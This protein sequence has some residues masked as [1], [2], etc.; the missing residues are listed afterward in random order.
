MIFIVFIHFHEGVV[1]IK[2]LNKAEGLIC[3]LEF[4][5]YT[6]SS[7]KRIKSEI[8]KIKGEVFNADGVA[9]WKISGEIKLFGVWGS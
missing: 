4:I 5:P 6:G 7:L 1:E 9:K 2:G 3:N 8:R